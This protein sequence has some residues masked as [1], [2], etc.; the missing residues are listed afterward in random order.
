[1]NDRLGSSEISSNAGNIRYYGASPNNYLDLGDVYETNTLDNFQKY[2]SVF[3]TFGVTTR[4][5]CKSTV[6]CSS[7]L[8]NVYFGGTTG[9]N[10]FLQSNF[11]TT[12]TNTICGEVSVEQGTPKALYRIIGLFKDVELADG[13]K[14]DLIKVVR[15][16]PAVNAAWDYADSSINSGLG[17]NAWSQ[18]DVLKLLN[19]GY[20]NEE[21]GGS[22]YWNNVDGGTCYGYNYIKQSY[23]PVN[24][25]FSASGLS[26]NVKD[27]IVE[28][29]WNTG[30]SDVAGLYSDKIYQDERSTNV[31]IPGVSCTGEKCT[32]TVTRYPTW[33][34]K[35]ALSYPSD[36]GYAADFRN[37]SSNL[38]NYDDCTSVNWMY[39][40]LT[41]GLQ[42]EQDGY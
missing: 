9:C 23:E 15:D 41:L 3:G 22:L 7:L 8:L 28:V 19:P 21:V 4:D 35:I 34:G 24:C 14:K 29:K 30:A 42:K 5:S 12:D 1:M 17:I 32:D 6:N 13:T 39:Q 25:N 11:G 40:T 33:T 20:E 10:A 27:K 37:C 38:A 2:T 36:Y 18:S 26:D 31:L 16:T